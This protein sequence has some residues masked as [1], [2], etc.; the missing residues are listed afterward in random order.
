MLTT[1]ERILFVVLLTG[2]LA[3]TAGGSGMMSPAEAQQ[4]HA[5]AAADRAGN[6]T[7]KPKLL[8]DHEYK[9][10]TKLAEIIVP[11]DEK[12]GS[13]VDAG[14]PEFIDLLC[15]QNPDLAAIYTGGILWLD[16]EMRRRHRFPLARFGEPCASP[17]DARGQVA[18]APREQDFLP[19]PQLLAQA[20]VAARLRRLA[21]QRAALLVHLEHDV[22]DAREVL[23]GGLELQ[24][25]GPTP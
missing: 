23:L 22:V 8:T 3:L 17:S 13:A 16:G 2:S 15:S 7:Y 18:I 19:P 6:G 11:A 12:S 10:V 25:R 4:V 24:L 21:L 1:V 14:A 5:A 9:T 20:L